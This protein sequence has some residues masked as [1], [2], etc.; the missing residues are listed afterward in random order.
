[1]GPRQERLEKF[2]AAVRV[3]NTQCSGLSC[4]MRFQIVILFVLN[5]RRIVRISEVRAGF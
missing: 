3:L 5:G 4:M 1:M 2:A